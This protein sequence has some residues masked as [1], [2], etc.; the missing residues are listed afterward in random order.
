M[1]AP[2]RRRSG[3]TTREEEVKPK[4]TI[5]TRQTSENQA[6]EN[7]EGGSTSTFPL[8]LGSLFRS[9]VFCRS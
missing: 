2:G 7:K 4:E 8:Y 1:R 3:I 9:I 6:Q 5:R